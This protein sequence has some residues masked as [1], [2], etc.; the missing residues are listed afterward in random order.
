MEERDHSVGMSQLFACTFS[1]SPFVYRVAYL[2]TFHT[3]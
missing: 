3:Q 1:F 2:F